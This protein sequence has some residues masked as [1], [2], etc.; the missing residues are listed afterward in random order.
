MGGSILGGPP[1]GPA[2][3][4]RA[5]HRQVNC[6]YLDL[7]SELK[8]TATASGGQVKIYLEVASVFW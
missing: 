8:A 5:E 1:P 2:G 3:R 4:T 6:R 7:P